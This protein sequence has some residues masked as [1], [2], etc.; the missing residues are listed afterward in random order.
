VILDFTN[1]ASR[2]AQ[3]SNELAGRVA[4]EAFCYQRGCFLCRVA[5][6]RAKLHV[7]AGATGFSDRVHDVAEFNGELPRNQ[8]FEP[9]NCHD[10]GK[11]TNRAAQGW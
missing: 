6:L 1:F 2:H 5:N 3:V 10:G 7:L 9:A 11:S 8:I 4:K